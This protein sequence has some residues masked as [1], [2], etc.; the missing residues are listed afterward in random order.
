METSTSQNAPDDKL[1]PNFPNYDEKTPNFDQSKRKQEEDSESVSVKSPKTRKLEYSPH[2][3]KNENYYRKKYYQTNE[4]ENVKKVKVNNPKKTKQ[5]RLVCWIK[6]SPLNQPPLGTCVTHVWNT[7]LLVL[8]R[9]FHH[10]PTNILTPLAAAAWESSP[11]EILAKKY[12][13]TTHPHQAQTACVN[14]PFPIT[15][16]SESAY[17]YVQTTAC[18]ERISCQRGSIPCLFFQNILTKN[19]RKNKYMTAFCANQTAV[20]ATSSNQPIKY[21]AQLWSIN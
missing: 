10:H 21:K 2:E 8:C 15:P 17:I 12:I 16:C 18:A 9:I 7:N 20:I 14:H 6:K 19:Q 13:L 5:S 1:I 11:F 3:N 4:S